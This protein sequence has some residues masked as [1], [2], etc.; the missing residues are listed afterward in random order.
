M[1]AT[2]IFL[3]NHIMTK[4]SIIIL[5]LLLTASSVM[6][7]MRFLETSSVHYKPTNWED[8]IVYIK[9]Q[10]VPKNAEKIGMMFCEGES[11]K[12]MFKLYVK[13]KKISAAYGATGI[14]MLTDAENNVIESRNVDTQ[15][16]R[17]NVERGKDFKNKI[18]FIAVRIPITQTTNDTTANQYNIKSGDLVMYKLDNGS[19]KKGKVLAINNFTK[20][21]IIKARGG[22]V[23]RLLIEITR[24][25]IE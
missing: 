14:Y 9:Q 15:E 10:E 1:L 25:D 2:L 8:V 21:A 20:T 16:K 7:R 11:P 24:I 19:I 6:A 13:A 5:T 23:E 12:E 18:T 22:N 4:A 17:Y 3:N